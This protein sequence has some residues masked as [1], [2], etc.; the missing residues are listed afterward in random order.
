[1]VKQS[2]ENSITHQVIN[3]TKN[4]FNCHCWLV[5]I[6]VFIEPT[7]NTNLSYI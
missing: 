2:T 4:S 6:W 5:K 3:D 1:M 7:T